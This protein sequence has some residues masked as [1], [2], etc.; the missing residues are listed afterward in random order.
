MQGSGTAVFLNG[1]PGS[2]KST[3]ARRLVDARAGWFLLDVDELRTSV[4]GWAEDFAG[5]GHV[6]RP[7]AQA[8]VRTVVACGG[9]VVMPQLFDDADELAA[10]TAEVGRG[11]GRAIHVLLD[12]P[13]D[14]CRRRLARRGQTPDESR[15][16]SLARVVDEALARAGGAAHLD[17]LAERLRLVCGGPVPAHRVDGRD[18]GRA[19]TEILELLDR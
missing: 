3:L 18:G 6:V 12:V 19:L 14:E 16:A 13:E 11:G 4:G 10:F 5:A 2:G 17:V 9:T 7:V 8:M 1:L 15:V